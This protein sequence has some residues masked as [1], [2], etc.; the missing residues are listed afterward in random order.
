MVS[1]VALL[2]Y[3]EETEGPCLAEMKEP[4]CNQSKEALELNVCIG[5]ALFVG[6]MLIRQHVDH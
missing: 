5:N 2:K 1:P 4:L 3:T 6:S